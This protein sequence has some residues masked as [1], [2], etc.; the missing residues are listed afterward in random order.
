MY[1]QQRF[2]WT[3]ELA[4]FKGVTGGAT[5]PFVALGQGWKYTIRPQKGGDDSFNMRYQYDTVYSQFL[6]Q[7]IN[8]KRCST[9][10]LLPFLTSSSSPRR[11][12]PPS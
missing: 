4:L 7:Q 3:S 12:P 5:V 6:G 2:K 10:A 9:L 1:T 11:P 8:L